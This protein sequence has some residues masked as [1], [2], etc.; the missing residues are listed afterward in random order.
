MYNADK[1]DKIRPG[2][3]LKNPKI[4]TQVSLPAYLDKIRTPT[5]NRYN[6]DPG[7]IKQVRVRVRMLQ[8]YHKKFEYF[9]DILHV[10]SLDHCLI[11]SYI[12]FRFAL[13]I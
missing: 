10:Y 4:G 7:S 11:S 5:Q 2:P 12:N 9:N 6:P 3:G 8:L 13:L 1:I